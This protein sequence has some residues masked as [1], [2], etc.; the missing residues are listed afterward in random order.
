MNDVVFIYVMGLLVI[1]S[2][3]V[4]VVELDMDLMKS[5]GV[6]SDG[7]I[8]LMIFLINNGMV[9]VYDVLIVDVFDDLVWDFGFFVLIIVFVGY[10]LMSVFGFGVGQFMVSFF[11]DG[12]V[13]LLLSFVEFLEMVQW[14]FFFNFVMLQLLSLVSNMVMNIF[15][16]MFL[17][18]DLSECDQFDVLVIDLLNLLIFDV[19]K[20]DVLVS[21]LNVFGGVLLGEMICYILQIINSG[22]VV[23][24]N[25]VIDDM[26]GVNMIFV[27]GSVVVL[28]GMVVIGN[29]G[30]DI[31]V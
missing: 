30:G 21:D 25:V 31:V 19:I 24:I 16:I 18:N 27:V 3:D 5:L 7:M 2:V 12:G 6:V 26:F 11:L 17:G 8:I 20:V 14:Q 10:L 23:V 15:V 13:I 9:L 29:I 1:D 4:D 28:G 22:S